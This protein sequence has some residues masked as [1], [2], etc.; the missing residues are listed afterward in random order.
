MHLASPRSGAWALQITTECAHN[1]R[2]NQRAKALT[3]HSKALIY[4]FPSRPIKIRSFHRQECQQLSLV[5]TRKNC[6][7]TKEKNSRTT[8]TEI[9]FFS[10]THNWCQSRQNCGLWFNLQVGLWFNLQVALSTSRPIAT[11]IAC[12]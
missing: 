9:R 10:R 3:P 6:D 11:S 5:K 8:K 4:F 2:L 1:S 7:S 12:M